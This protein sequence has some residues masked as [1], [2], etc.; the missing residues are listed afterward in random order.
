MSNPSVVTLPHPTASS[1]SP[2]DTTVTDLNISTQEGLEAWVYSTYLKD[3]FDPDGTFRSY[4]WLKSHL[5]SQASKVKN[6][7]IRQAVN[8]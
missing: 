6:G 5:I 4:K 2:A 3:G 1:A 7:P 8:R